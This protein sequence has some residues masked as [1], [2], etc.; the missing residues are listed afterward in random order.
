MVDGML[1]IVIMMHAVVLMGMW[2]WL[3]VLLAELWCGAG[4]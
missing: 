3:F 2:K 4:D 1:W